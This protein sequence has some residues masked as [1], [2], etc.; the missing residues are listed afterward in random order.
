MGRS[1]IALAIS[2]AVLCA[3]TDSHGILLG[4][5]SGPDAPVHDAP[6]E[7]MFDPVPDPPIPDAPVPDVVDIVEEPDWPCTPEFSEQR[8]TIMGGLMVSAG[9]EGD[10]DRPDLATL[11][12]GEVWLSGRIWSSPSA[13]DTPKLTLV[14]VNPRYGLPAGI[15][16]HHLTNTEVDAYHPIVPLGDSMVV[17]YPDMGDFSASEVLAMRMDMPPYSGELT[18]FPGTDVLSTQPAAASN[19]SEIMAVW[20]QGDDTG[21]NT[22]IDFSIVSEAG[23]IVA[24]GRAYGDGSSVLRAPTLIHAGSSYRMACFEDTSSYPG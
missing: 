18:A 2:V 4:D 21:M 14:S 23:E 1:T 9:E 20:R 12:S 5:T 22:T 8:R 19:G 7:T 3:C 6:E 24:G 16:H 17:V 10:P 15:W 13:M 11:P